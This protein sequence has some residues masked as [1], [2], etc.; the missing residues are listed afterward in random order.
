[1]ISFCVIFFGDFD[2]L[3]MDYKE[4]FDER[5]IGSKWGYILS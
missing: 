5:L 4:L 2:S 3:M 1:M